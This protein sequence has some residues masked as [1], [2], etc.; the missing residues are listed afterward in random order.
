MES[1]DITV[2]SGLLIATMKE[3]CRKVYLSGHKRLLAAMYSCNI[4]TSADVLGKLYGIIA[5]RNGEIVQED[6]I[7][8]I[9]LEL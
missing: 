6:M 8:G 9:C 2:T 5:K 4:Q 3:A 7:E 1:F